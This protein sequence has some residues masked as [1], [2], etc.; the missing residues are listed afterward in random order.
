MTF[1]ATF[2]SVRGEGAKI[3]RCYTKRLPV[4]FLFG[5]NVTKFARFQTFKVTCKCA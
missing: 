2:A 3:H 4:R 1:K 5:K